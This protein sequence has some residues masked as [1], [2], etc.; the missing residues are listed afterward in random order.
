[1]TLEEAMDLVINEAESSA[2]NGN[3]EDEKVVIEAVKMVKCFY[4]EFG[5][6]FDNYENDYHYNPK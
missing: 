2:L 6:Q 3:T 5:Y 1:M 4:D